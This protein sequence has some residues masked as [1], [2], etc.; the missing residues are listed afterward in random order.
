MPISPTY[1]GGSGSE[2]NDARTI[3]Q[4]ILYNLMGEERKYRYRRY[5]RRMY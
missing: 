4:G 5:G 1:K 2:N 3:L